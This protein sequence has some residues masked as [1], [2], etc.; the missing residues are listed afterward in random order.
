M[1]QLTAD[2]KIRVLVFP[3]FENKEP[4]NQELIDDARKYEIGEISEKTG[5]QKCMVNGRIIWLLPHQNGF[6][7]KKITEGQMKKL[8]RSAKKARPDGSLNAPTVEGARNYMNYIMKT[9][10]K[11]P[12]RSPFFN[13]ARIRLDQTSYN[14]LFEE[15]PGIKRDDPDI[16]RRAKCLP[17]LRDILER[18]GKPARHVRDKYNEDEYTVVGKA[19]IEGQ[20]RGIKAVIV[21]RTDGHYYYLSVMDLKII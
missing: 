7:D 9:W 11:N 18:T 13:N 14:H 6:T 3:D 8:A 19:I 10:R 21:R 2:T 15:K 20:E 4:R 12:V 17:F 1:R 5:L 16:V